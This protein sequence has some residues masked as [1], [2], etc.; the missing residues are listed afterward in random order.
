MQL[1][2]QLQRE[3]DLPVPRSAE[4]VLLLRLGL[5]E[6]AAGSGEAHA[7]AV[8]SPAGTP[9]SSTPRRSSVP[10]SDPWPW[11]SC[12]TFTHRTALL[13]LPEAPS[14][15]H[16]DTPLKPQSCRV[17]TKKS[18]CWAGNSDCGIGLGRPFSRHS[19]LV[20]RQSWAD[21]GGSVRT[22]LEEGAKPTPSCL[23]AR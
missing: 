23:A 2:P 21:T 18:L 1:S 6:T 22:R 3:P 17:P 13:L 7:G 12:R 9:V 16:S 15:H 19:P 14:G 20:G 8:A 11:P 4:L 10:C 5:E